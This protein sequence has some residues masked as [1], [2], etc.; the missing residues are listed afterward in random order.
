MDVLS[1]W[2]SGIKNVVALSGTSL[3]EDHL[4]RLRRIADTVIVSFDNDEAGLRALERGLDFFNR[5]DFHVR[6]VDLG[7]FEDPAEACQ[8]D[9]TFLPKAIEAAKPS[10]AYL[11]ENYFP[12]GKTLEVA[13]QKR[14]LRHLLTKIGNIKSAIEQGA[15]V[16]ALARASG[17][18]EIAL[19]SELENL[20]PTK[21]E[22]RGPAEAQKEYA[23]NNPRRVQLVAERLLSLAFS[24]DELVT[25]LQSNREWLP[26][27]YQ[28]IFDDPSSED[29]VSLQLRS[30]YE[31]GETEPEEI[32]KEFDLLLKYLQIESLKKQQAALKEKIRV[33]QSNEDLTQFSH[34]SQKINELK[35]SI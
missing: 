22:E 18:S 28:N 20:A 23:S 6:A 14:V 2:Q 35:S 15:W 30:S 3:S 34:V 13:E 11:F 9:P 32:Q 17:V 21:V 19:Q 31:L 25:R 27:S 10:F 1:V 29:A 26:A 5:F 7:K 16:K 24:K 8:Q 33:G 12:Q 4:A